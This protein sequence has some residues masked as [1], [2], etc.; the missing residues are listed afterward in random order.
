MN[1]SLHGIQSRLFRKDVNHGDS[2]EYIFARAAGILKLAL[3]ECYLPTLAANFGC[4]LPNA[5]LKFLNSKHK[6]LK[7]KSACKVKLGGK[8][9]RAAARVVLKKKIHPGSVVDEVTPGVYVSSGKGLLLAM[10]EP[11]AQKCCCIIF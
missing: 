1:E 8:Q 5:A 2:I 4:E 3:G 11:V 9:K 6:V 10:S 7:T